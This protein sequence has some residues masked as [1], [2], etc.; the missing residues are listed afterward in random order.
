M[1]KIFDFFMFM[2][3]LFLAIISAIG[4]LFS[5]LIAESIIWHIIMFIIGSFGCYVFK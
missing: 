1:N 2:L 3:C 5:S 4:I